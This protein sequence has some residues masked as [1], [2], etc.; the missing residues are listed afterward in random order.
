MMRIIKLIIILIVLCGL[1]YLFYQRL[2]QTA[3]FLYI[4]PSFMM[5]VILP[6]FVVINLVLR[7]KKNKR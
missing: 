7:N 3:H 5:Y 6:L 1:S 2:S 4:I